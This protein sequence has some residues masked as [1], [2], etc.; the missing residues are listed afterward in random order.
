MTAAARISRDVAHHFATEVVDLLRPACERIEIAG[1]LRR[2]KADV[3]DIELLAVPVL[4]SRTVDLFGTQEYTAP[5]DALCDRLVSVGILEYRL[6]K[7]GRRAWGARFKRALYQGV[8]LDLF[9]CRPPA[10]WGVLLAIRTGPA[11]FSHRL[12]TQQRF[13]GLLPN[14]WSVKDGALHDADGAL[15][16][17]H[18]ERDLF[19]AIG[20]EYVE[21]GARR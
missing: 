1:S 17:T 8:A 19:A 15:V 10:Q 3:K 6:D 13:G 14:Y 18:E 7:L 12:V 21:P 9:V 11:E 16:E 5:L 20:V 2:G 4:E